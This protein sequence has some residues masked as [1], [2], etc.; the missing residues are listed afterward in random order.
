MLA[1]KTYWLIGASDGLGRALAHALDREGAALVLSARN[2]DRLDDLALGLNNARVLPLDVT[3]ADAVARAASETTD[4]DGLIYCA[5]TYD[6]MAAQDWDA[7]AAMQMA[8]VNFL[9][10]MRVLGHVAPRL[11]HKG[12]GHIMLV[13]SLSGFR[14]LPGA[15]GYSASKAALMNLGES[16]YAD[17]RKTG[18]KVQIASPG[19]IRTRL[20]EKNDFPMPQ[21]ME[22]EDAAA[23]ILRAM[24]GDR[25][26]TAFPRPF[27]LIFTLG[28]FLPAPLFARLMGA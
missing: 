12:A 21:I 13:G 23:R 4:C 17:L 2:K 7:S 15:I 8:E 9:G 26:H 25:T 10:A 24:Q 3:D 18:V 16:L 11:A 20:S 28:R 22:P 27:S 19:F 14:G 6:P 1:A 5:G